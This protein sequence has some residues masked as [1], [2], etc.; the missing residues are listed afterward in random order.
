MPA[1]SSWLE[2]L[3]LEHYAAIFEENGVDLESLPLLSESDFEKLGVLLGHRKK[4]LKALAELNDT[5][6]SDIA[7]QSKLSAAHRL[8][9]EGERRQATALFSDLSGY[10][11]L[12]EKR[13]S[14]S[15]TVERL[16]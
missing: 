10:T 11:A 13:P 2:L 7:A 12:N 8:A 3:G 4:L 5:T 16:N 9:V 1:L 14:V 15:V 6:A